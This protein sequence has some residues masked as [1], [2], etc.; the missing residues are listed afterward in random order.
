MR[1]ICPKNTQG[2]AIYTIGGLPVFKATIDSERDGMERI[3]LVDSPAVERDFVRM[4][5][6]ER[7]PVQFSVASEERQLLYGVIMRAN[8]PIYRRDPE[9]GEFFIVYTPELIRTMAEKYIAEGRANAFNLQHQDGSDVEGVQ[10]VQWFI[11]DSARGIA[12]AEFP[13]VEDGSLFGEFH[14]TDPGLW[15]R[16]KAGEFRGFSLEGWYGMDPATGVLSTEKLADDVKE[17]LDL[18]RQEEKPKNNNMAKM[19]RIKKALARFVAVRMGSVSTDNGVLFWDGDGELEAG[20]NVYQENED[21]EWV[22]AADGEYKIEDYVI[23]VADGKVAEVREAEAVQPEEP[24]AEAPAAEAEEQK[25]EEI[26]PE[27][28]ETTEEVVEEIVEEVND[29]EERIDALEA[30][31]AALEGALAELAARLEEFAKTPAGKPA[32][33]AAKEQAGNAARKSTSLEKALKYVRK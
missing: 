28:E 7:R 1:V 27:P 22:P 18:Q 25:A 20:V 31:V 10:M 19:N 14:V 13:D 3:S 21:G 29:K 2:M 9:L 15:E 26:A 11:K 4:A 6:A 33:V 24:A 8:F 16:C 32:H 5:S 30:R 12:P 23:V 17:Y